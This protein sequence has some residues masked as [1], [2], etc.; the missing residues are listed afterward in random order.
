MKKLFRLACLALVPFVSGI[1]LLMLDNPTCNRIGSFIMSI[2]MPVTL[3]ILVV[4]GIIMMITGRLDDS[5]KP[6]K[7]RGSDVTGAP[8]ESQETPQVDPAFETTAEREARELSDIN[9]SY[10]YDSRYKSA[11]YQMSH[12]A[13]NYK[14]ASPK[15]KVLGWLFLGFLLSAFGL[16]LVSILLGWS[17]G[18]F[19]GIGV[20]GGTIIISAIV[21]VILEKTSIS[22]KFDIEKYETTNATVKACLL[23]SMSSTGGSHNYSTVRVGKVTYRIVLDVDGK[24]FTAYSRI[25]YDEGQKLEVA[26][27]KNGR[28]VAKILDDLSDDE[29]AERVEAGKEKIIDAE[30][31]L[32]RRLAEAEKQYRE[33][34]ARL[35]AIK[36]G[37]VLPPD[38]ENK[39]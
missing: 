22:T 28:G 17:L 14:H 2:G 24:E 23:S 1:V 29:I 18:F 6:K 25:P 4:I 36:N 20:F 37:E 15:E 31:D 19:I 27:R 35:N 12:V 13:H 39:L 16:A 11:E 33:K 9:S 21:K 10:G 7:R 3:F 32:D 5:R 30:A 34:M 38:D 26:V 8:D